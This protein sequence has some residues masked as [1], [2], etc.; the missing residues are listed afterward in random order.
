MES[1][2]EVGR[3]DASS[4]EIIEASE[5]VVGDGAEQAYR[6][7]DAIEKRRLMQDWSCYLA[8]G[9]NTGPLIAPGGARMITLA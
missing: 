5:H 8:S 1:A 4:R 2:R 6:R 7:T 9:G 3:R